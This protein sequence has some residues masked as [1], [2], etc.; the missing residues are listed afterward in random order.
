MAKP[1]P[2][3]QKIDAFLAGAREILYTPAVRVLANM[4]S[5]GE[6]FWL[7]DSFEEMQD[8]VSKQIEVIAHRALRFRLN[9]AFGADTSE[10]IVDF[11]NRSGSVWIDERDRRVTPYVIP[12]VL[13]L[14]WGL[15]TEVFDSIDNTLDIPLK[16]GLEIILKKA[17]D[18]VPDATKTL[19][20]IEER[21]AYIEAYDRACGQGRIVL[22]DDSFEVWISIVDALRQTEAATATK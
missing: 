17:M 9:P 21:G 18:Q 16:L 2:D 15:A 6:H 19:Y 1:L 8:F 5:S 20:K 22:T 13:I 4:D 10:M 12:L 3:T 7:P 11:R 14:K